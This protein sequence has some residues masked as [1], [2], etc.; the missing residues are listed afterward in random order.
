MYEYYQ[1][2][3]RKIYEAIIAMVVGGM[4]DF[5]N[6]LTGEELRPEVSDAADGYKPG[7]PLFRVNAM[8]TDPE[9][10]FYPTVVDVQKML[11]KFLV[12]IAESAKDFI[13]WL[14]GTCDEAQPVEIDDE[15]SYI[16]HF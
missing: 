7:T 14:D 4:T 15:N 9:L 2:W 5:M 6:L 11:R 12:S 13:R 3:E 16:F 10:L 8:F 1:H